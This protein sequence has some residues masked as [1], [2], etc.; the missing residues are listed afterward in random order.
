MAL[1]EM[2][3]EGIE[4]AYENLE[5]GYIPFRQL[6]LFKESLIKSKGARGSGVFLDPMKGGEGKCM[7]RRTNA[8]RI[9]DVGGRLMASRQYPVINEVFNPPS[10]HNP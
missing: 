10:K 8:Q 6:A 3:F 5:D 1:G 9:Q 4:K 2:D 7:G